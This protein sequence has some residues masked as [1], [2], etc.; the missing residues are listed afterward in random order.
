MVDSAVLEG[1][2]ADFGIETYQKIVITALEVI[3][4]KALDNKLHQVTPRGSDGAGKANGAPY[5]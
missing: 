3:V 1:A 4:G 5:M 2:S